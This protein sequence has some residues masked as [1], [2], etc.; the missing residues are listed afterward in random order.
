MTPTILDTII[1]NKRHE[2]AAVMS[3]RP[4]D[5]LRRD[6]E[7]APPPRDFHR[8]VIGP[9]GAEGIRLIAEIKK[10]SPSAGLIR[11]DFDPVAIGRTYETAGA[12]A[13]SILTDSVY[14]H[15]RLAF[16][17]AVK[18]RVSIPILRKDFI[19]DPYQVFESRAAG[20]DAVLLIAAV[21]TPGEIG[22]LATLSHQ[23]GMSTLIEVHNEAE[24]RGVL[25]FVGSDRKTLLGINNRDLKIQK[26]NLDTTRRLAALLAPGT[27]FVAES[28]I[29]SRND[30]LTVQRHGATAMLV[31]EA[32]M[33]APDI[34]RETRLLLG[35]PA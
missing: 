22:A 8:A 30:A 16:I 29:A 3:A 9:A 27:P 25:P 18:Q 28:G 14:F 1:E 34:A 32:L 35:H 26:T 31:G 11:A 15:G 33:R 13:L 2:L 19:I 20:A 17:A 4:L 21:L 12:S 5:P 23:L 6:A 7:A 10:A 24:L